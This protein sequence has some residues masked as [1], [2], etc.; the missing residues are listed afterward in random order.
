METYLTCIWRNFCT[1]FALF[2]LHISH[3]YNLD[4]KR[5]NLYMKNVFH[6]SH[7]TFQNWMHVYLDGDLPN[8]VYDKNFARNSQYF[9]SKA[10]LQLRWNL[11]KPLYE[12]GFPHSSQNYLIALLC[13][14]WQPGLHHRDQVAVILRHPDQ[15]LTPEITGKI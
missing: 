8:L 6:T 14:I 13:P 3:V 10:C 2:C 4:G 9:W 15:I 12:N 7:N 5:F 11:I 1:Q